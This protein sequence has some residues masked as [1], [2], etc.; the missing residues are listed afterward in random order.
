VIERWLPER[1]LKAQFVRVV[2]RE[3]GASAADRMIAASRTEEMITGTVNR[4]PFVF[5]LKSNRC[6]MML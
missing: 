4:V 3:H 2:G 1:F 5:I 6:C